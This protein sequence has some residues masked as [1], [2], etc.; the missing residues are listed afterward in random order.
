MNVD[1][2]PTGRRELF[3]VRIIDGCPPSPASSAARTGWPGIGFVRAV[4]PSYFAQSA[5]PFGCQA[6]TCGFAPGRGSVTSFRTAALW[7]IGT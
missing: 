6:T 1:F 5:T 4:R 3:R 2:V 7:I